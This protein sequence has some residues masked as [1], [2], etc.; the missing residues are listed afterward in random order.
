MIDVKVVS[1]DNWGGLYIDDE[2][3]FETHRIGIQDITKFVDGRPIESILEFELTW[4]DGEAWINEVMGL[5][6]D[7]T[8]SEMVEFLA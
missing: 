4:P 5:P 8:D 6:E 3:V 7:F 2:L 1:G